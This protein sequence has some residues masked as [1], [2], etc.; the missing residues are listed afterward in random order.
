MSSM[1]SQ[2]RFCRSET[3]EILNSLD[4]DQL[5]FCPEGDKWKPLFKQF[6]C[7]VSTQI[8]YARSIEEGRID[9]GWF[10]D[11]T[12]KLENIST[13]EDLLK[14]LEKVD[15]RWVKVI[16]SIEDEDYQ[17]KWP[18][19]SLNLFNTITTLISHERLHDGQ[20]ISYFTMA[21]FDLPEKFKENWAL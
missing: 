5:K 6:V 7:M 8:T 21:G 14:A 20:I 13:K 12:A 10:R 19:F 15:K 11:E 9:F 17:I 4:D 18:G 1:L 16:K 2:W 3:L